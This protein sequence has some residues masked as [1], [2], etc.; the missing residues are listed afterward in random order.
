M[1]RPTSSSAACITCSVFF[2]THFTYVSIPGLYSRYQALDNRQQLAPLKCLAIDRSF[3]RVLQR[4]SRSIQTLIFNHQS[5]TLF[6]AAVCV[7]SYYFIHFEPLKITKSA[8]SSTQYSESKIARISGQA[9]HLTYIVTYFRALSSFQA[10]RPEATCPLL[11]ESD[12]SDA[13][14]S[15]KSLSI[16]ALTD[17]VNPLLPTIYRVSPKRTPNL[18]K[19]RCRSTP[20][21]RG[22]RETFLNSAQTLTVTMPRV[23]HVKHHRGIDDLTATLA[24]SVKRRGKPHDEQRCNRQSA[25]SKPLV[26]W[27]P[28]DLPKRRHDCS[29]RAGRRGACRG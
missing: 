12:S 26:Q 19:P 10:R 6:I 8:S 5:A 23:K 21:V 13:F 4:K 14:A 17:L 20:T 28:V 22:T 25:R 24:R 27:S 1:H 18:I 16:T 11:P 29:K 7:R 3:A 9:S 15:F 2:L